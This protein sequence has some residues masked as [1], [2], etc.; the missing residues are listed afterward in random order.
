MD[1]GP[2]CALG[3]EP[4]SGNSS[5]ELRMIHVLISGQC[6]HLRQL[7]L[8]GT[9]LE[10]QSREVKKTVHQVPVRRPL[11]LP[12]MNNAFFD[13]HKES[14]PKIR[15]GMDDGLVRNCERRAG[16]SSGEESNTNTPWRLE[17]DVLDQCTR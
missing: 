3:V 12:K 2:L 9:S 7:T 15:S 4:L 13:L 17:K 1:Q 8:I 14:G 10:T 16:L 11:A 6:Q 5:L